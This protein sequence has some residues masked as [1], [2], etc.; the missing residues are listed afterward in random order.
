MV[1]HLSCLLLKVTS[2]LCGAVLLCEKSITITETIRTAT[3]VV[4]GK[5]GMKRRF[6]CVIPCSHS[7]GACQGLHQHAQ[8]ASALDGKDVGPT[9][10][11][12]E[13]GCPLFPASLSHSGL[14]ARPMCDASCADLARAISPPHTSS[15]HGTCFA[16]PLAFY[17]CSGWLAVCSL[18]LAFFFPV[19]C[20]LVLSSRRNGATACALTHF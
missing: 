16:P 13:E 19:F 20:T 10:A 9:G 14:P 8:G 15:P 4:L 2:H 7:L 3:G 6:M 17:F 11:E 12:P 1:S 18:C 5:P